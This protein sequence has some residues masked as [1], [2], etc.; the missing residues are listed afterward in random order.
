VKPIDNARLHEMAKEIDDRY[1]RV[2]EKM[3]QAGTWTDE[4]NARFER[5]YDAFMARC[6]K[7]LL[8]NE[9]IG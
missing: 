5:M 3:D 7:Y 8:K 6:G 2:M 4:A 9:G 1:M